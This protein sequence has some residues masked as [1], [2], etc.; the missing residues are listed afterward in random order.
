[1]SRRRA[2]AGPC[3]E[4][5]ENTRQ[6]TATESIG[7]KRKLPEPGAAWQSRGTKATNKTDEH[8]R[9]ITPAGYVAEADAFR[10]PPQPLLKD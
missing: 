3:V 4:E 6:V 7:L 10:P 2:L 1:M 9:N 8:K 5:E